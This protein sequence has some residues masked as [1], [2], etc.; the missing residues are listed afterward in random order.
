[1]FYHSLIFYTRLENKLST[2]VL[3]YQAFYYNLRHRLN[4]LVSLY[5]IRKINFSVW[6][7]F[8][9]QKGCGIV[10]AGLHFSFNA[11]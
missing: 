11:R 4:P 1:M 5:G 3:G 2:N 6:E 10:R 7:G 9:A 8:S